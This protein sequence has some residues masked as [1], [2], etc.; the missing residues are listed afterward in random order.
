MHDPDDHGTKDAE[1][2]ARWF[3]AAILM[4]AADIS[5]ELPDRADWKRLLDL[6]QRRNVS[7]QALLKR[8]QTLGVMSD[9]TYLQAMKTL[10]ARGWRMTSRGVSG[11]PSDRP[12]S[13]ELSR[14]SLTR[15]CRI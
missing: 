11:H 10:S 1:Q 2:Q 6:K 8:A 5:H 15:A 13:P 4:P 3:A 7:V 9:H 14:S 12:S